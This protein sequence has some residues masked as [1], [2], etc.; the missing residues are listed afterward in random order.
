MLTSQATG[1]GKA[2]GA[3]TLLAM[4]A[5]LSV[6]VATASA[7]VSL[8]AAA[9]HAVYW[10]LEREIAFRHAEV[11]LA[12]AEADLRAAFDDPRRRRL[13]PFPVPGTCGTGMQQGLCMPSPAIAPPWERWLAPDMQASPNIGVALGRFTGTQVPAIA[14]EAGGGAPPPR[15]LIEVLDARAPSGSAFVAGSDDAM[16][17]P[18][19]FRI[20]AIGYGREPAVRAVLQTEWLG[21]RKSTPAHDRQP[22]GRFSWRELVPTPASLCSN[23]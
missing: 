7:L 5:M 13:S 11:A 23:C 15:Y 3:V 1:R 14:G 22:S 2:A 18:M 19:A 17:L 4:V 12:D 16:P 9:H 6:L 21:P 10:R 8:M 20:T